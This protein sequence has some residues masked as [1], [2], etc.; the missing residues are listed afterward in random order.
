MKKMI[1]KAYN[2]KRGLEYKISKNISVENLA[3]YMGI[4]LGASQLRSRGEDE[5]LSV[6]FLEIFNQY[7][8][9]ASREPIMF[10]PTGPD[11]D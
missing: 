7:F 10:D 4:L 9:M 5:E 6:K 2:G 1:F 3:S 8:C 11:R